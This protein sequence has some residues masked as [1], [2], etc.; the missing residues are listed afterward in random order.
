VG[1]VTKRAGC[2]ALL[3][4]VGA[5]LSGCVSGEG[6]GG[7]E[8]A[9]P[10]MRLPA[11]FRSQETLTAHGMVTVLLSMWHDAAAR[12]DFDGYFSKMTPDGVFLGTDRT[13]RWTR[14]AF[15]AFARPYFDGVEAWTYEAVE[16]HVIVG[17]GADPSVAWFDEVLWNAK[18]GHCR[19]SGVAVRG[20]DG[21]WRIAHYT[22]SLLV[23]NEKAPGVVRLIGEVEDARR[24]DATGGR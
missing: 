3:A 19:G 8:T 2:A 15:E 14:E 7:D 23:P 17:P 20:E 4:G 21:Q 12:G 24:G 18:Y 6:G 16:R 13:E 9:S 1:R 11:H 5:I 22:L 10:A